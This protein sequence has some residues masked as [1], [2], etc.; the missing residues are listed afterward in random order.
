M[1]DLTGWPE[2]A[3]AKNANQLWSKDEFA[4]WLRDNGGVAKC[5][6]QPA[7]SV[8]SRW[9]HWVECRPK[10][11]GGTMFVHLEDFRALADDGRLKYNGDRR[12]LE[13]ILS[14]SS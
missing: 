5:T 4:K 14:E 13:F 6:I 8:S 2:Y 10:N 12:K 3:L 1:P 11:G 7:A 9:N